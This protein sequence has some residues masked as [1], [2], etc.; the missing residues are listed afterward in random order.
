M[1]IAVKTKTRPY[2][3]RPFKGNTAIEYHY[4]INL[5]KKIKLCSH[6]SLYTSSKK[7]LHSFSNIFC[8]TANI[9]YSYLQI[10]C[11]RTFFVP[12]ATFFVREHFFFPFGTFFAHDSTPPRTTT[13]LLLGP[14]RIARGQNNLYMLFWRLNHISTFLTCRS[15]WCNKKFDCDGKIDKNKHAFIEWVRVP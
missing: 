2:E 11:S 3:A 1:L 13:K 8:S 5:P 4:F 12:F 10:F 7:V 14:L 15:E 6:S 9:I